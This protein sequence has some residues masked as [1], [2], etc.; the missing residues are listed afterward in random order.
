MSSIYDR[1]PLVKGDNLFFAFLAAASRWV[2]W[3]ALT[4][5]DCKYTAW[6]APGQPS[7]FRPV[8]ERAGRDPLRVSRLA[9]HQSHLPNEQNMAP[10]SP[11]SSA[12]AGRSATR[13]MAT[14]RCDHVCRKP[15][16]WQ[17]PA[18]ES[19]HSR[20]TRCGAMRPFTRAAQ[21]SDLDDV[22]VDAR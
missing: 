19:L 12:Y 22:H 18:R 16:P 15:L 9:S 10:P 17:R 6:G 2:R 14:R 8:Q 11:N 7:S 1:Q 20:L 3:T 21:P 13:K 4:T 5:K